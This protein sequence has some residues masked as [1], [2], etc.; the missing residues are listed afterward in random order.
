MAV[1]R[2]TTGAIVVVAATVVIAVAVTG[3]FSG[4][5]SLPLPFA[6]PVKL[7]LP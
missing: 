6:L 7:P 5:L 2:V 4:V 3:N 1:S